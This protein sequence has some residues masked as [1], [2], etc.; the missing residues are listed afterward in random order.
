MVRFN[1]KTYKPGTRDC[2]RLAAHAMHKMGVAVPL[3]KGVKYTTEAGA[4]KALKRMGFASLMEAVDALGLKRIGPAS[5]LPGDIVALPTEAGA[6]GCGLMV[7][8]DN[9]RV[10]GF[11]DGV[12]GVFEPLKF[13]AAWR[14]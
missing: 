12:C 11:A 5:T 8:A 10:I 2:A 6:F 1:G 4:A 13:I 14:V 7:K 3:L 9:G